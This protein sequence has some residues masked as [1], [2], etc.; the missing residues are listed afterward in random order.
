VLDLASKLDPS[1]IWGR[2]RLLPSQAGGLARHCLRA[3][4]EISAVG[5]RLVFMDLLALLLLLL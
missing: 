5:K 4:K 3:A 1:L 2:F